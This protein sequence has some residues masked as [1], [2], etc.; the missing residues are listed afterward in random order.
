VSSPVRPPVG[1]LGI[2][3][4]PTV[5]EQQREVE[6]AVGILGLVSTAVG[7]R[8][9]LKVSTRLQQD[10]EVAGSSDVPE[11]RRAL[12]RPFGTCEVAPLFEQGGNYERAFDGIPIL[13]GSVCVSCDSS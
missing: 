5:L 11:A 9:T 7:P 13:G 1:G 8:G 12:V 3:Q 10:A 6:G 4:A 2:R